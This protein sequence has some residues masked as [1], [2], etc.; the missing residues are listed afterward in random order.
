MTT[1]SAATSTAFLSR[2]PDAAE[3]YNAIDYAK[4]VAAPTFFTTLEPAFQRA[5]QA[6]MAGGNVADELKKA[7]TQVEGSIGQ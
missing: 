2:N 5:L 7:Q 3:L 4:P 6:I 1:K